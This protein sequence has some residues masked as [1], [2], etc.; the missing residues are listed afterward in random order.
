MGRLM[1]AHI[2]VMD[3]VAQMKAAEQA[4]VLATV[5]RTVS[6]TAAKA[7]AKAII[8][9]DGTIVAGWIGGGCARGAV[10]KA[11][12]EALADGAPR[13][14]SV[15]PED[16]LAELGVKPGENRGGIR[17]ASNMCPSQGTMDI[18]VEPVLPHPSLIIFGASPVAMSLAAQARQLGYHVTLAAPAADLAAVPDA[19]TLIDGFALGELNQ[20]RRFVVVSTQGKGDEA[21]LRAAVATDAEYRA[22]VG[23]RRKMAAL[24]E[25][26]IA[27]GTAPEVIDRVKAP[28]GLDIGAITP[29]EIAMSILAEIT[30]ERRRG[31]RQGGTR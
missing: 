11:A 14:V 28:A 29:E 2:E 1:T 20:A 5:V 10:L 16:M 3:L 9:P 25:K 17:F 18:F 15:Q 24:R 30:V 21:A 31:Q 7:G 8:R 26:F 6:V 19:D 23:S 4:F 27:A 12:R 13:M 22:F